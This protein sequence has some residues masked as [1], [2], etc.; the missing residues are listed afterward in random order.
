V[1]KP[2]ASRLE[3]CLSI[4][5]QRFGPRLSTVADVRRQHANTLT[6]LENQPPDAVIWPTSTL[7]VAEIVSLASAHKVPLIAYGAGTSLEG[8]LNAPFG[9]ISVD[10]SRMDRIVE[11]NARDLDCRVE[12]GVSRR[13]LN[14]HLRDQGLF[15]PVD[16]GAEEAT[17]GG[18][19]ATRASGTT[20]VRYG[21]MRENVLNVTAVM[22]D[23]SIVKTGSR[24]RKSA[25]GYDLTRL[26][27]GSEGTLGI[28]TELTLR[29]YG[30]PESML[31]AV[32]PFATLEGACNAA[33]DAVGQ[34]LGVARI[35]L[36]DATQIAAVNVHAKLAL[37]ETPTLFLE[38]HGTPAATR[39]EVAAFEAIAR[40]N[41]ALRFDWAATEDDRRRLWKARHEAYWAIRATAK[42][43]AIL[44]TDVCVPVSRLAQCVLETVEDAAQCGLTAPILGHVGDGNFHA[45]PLIDAES[46]A[47]V[48]ALKG[49]L[50]RLAARAIAHG[51][52][53]TGEHGIGQ[54][55]KA[56]L[57]AEAGTALPVMATI[58]R[59]LDPDGLLNPGK[60]IEE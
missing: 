3:L 14:E 31:A 46:P 59:A 41:G 35:E 52:T 1:T 29:L 11:V 53:C 48:A 33:M 50:G 9:G 54:G 4:L 22:A 40:D 5:A 18:M 20:T 16:P 15:F 58:K 60:I 49:F 28:I 2:D 39:A 26:L 57:A 24:A 55:K 10:M 37:E 8:H 23:G 38:F 7:E 34:G 56:Y 19:A 51:G 42:G 6:W 27:I 12:A 45:T 21:S 47:E 43:R 32:C 30:I 13:R 36:L 17:L 25:A 44:A